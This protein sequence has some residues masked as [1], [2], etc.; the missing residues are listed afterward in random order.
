[1]GDRREIDGRGIEREC[2]RLL[3]R[4]VLAAFVAAEFGVA[5]V[6]VV[7]G[8]APATLPPGASLNRVVLARQMD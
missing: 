5:L 2:R 3:S 7:R 8:A 6:T 1:M 4:D